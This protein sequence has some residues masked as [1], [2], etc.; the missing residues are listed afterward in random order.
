MRK[1]AQGTHIGVA[2]TIGDVQ[3]VVARYRG[4]RFRQM[5]DGPRNLGLFLFDYAGYSISFQFPLG[6][7]EA[8]RRRVYRAAYNSVKF[9][10]ESVASGIESPAQAF[11]AHIV[12]DDG[13]LMMDKIRPLLPARRHL[14][15]K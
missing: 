15:V 1:F 8:E 2:Q 3:S 6:S 10:L 7:N 9:K 12:A 4:D 13:G 14:V 5:L 11:A